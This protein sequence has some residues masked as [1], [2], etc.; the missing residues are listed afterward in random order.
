M[1][2]SQIDALF[3]PR[4]T[5]SFK[6]TAGEKGMGLGL[7]LCQRFVD[8][9]QGKISVQSKEGEGTTFKVSLPLALNE[10]QALSVE[11]IKHVVLE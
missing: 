2:Q 11:N 1:S 9:N 5:A 7:V 10:H 3:Q 4:L 8:L 6:G